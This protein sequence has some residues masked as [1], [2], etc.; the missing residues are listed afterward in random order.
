MIDCQINEI[1]L[2]N[3]Y[4]Q[5]GR[6]AVTIEANAACRKSKAYRLGQDGNDDDGDGDS[7]KPTGK[8]KKYLGKD[9]H[10]Y[11]L[12]KDTSAWKDMTW[13]QKTNF[14]K[15]RKAWLDQ[16]LIEYKTSRKN[17]DNDNDNERTRTKVLR[18]SIGNV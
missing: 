1:D 13:K 9:F 14:Q 16:G 3:W 10:K 17:K 6:V 5:I 11:G 15:Q 12:I 4:E 7:N 18:K 8:P 2:I